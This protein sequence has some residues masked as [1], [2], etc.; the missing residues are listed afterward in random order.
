M[1][2]R[3]TP[4]ELGA[5]RARVAQN[6]YDANFMWIA[7]GDPDVLSAIFHT[8]HPGP[9]FNRGRYS[10]P[11]VDGWLEQAGATLDK[12]TRIRLYSQI[13]QRVL[14]D[15]AV[16]PLI[17]T[18]TYNAKRVEVKGDIIDALGDYV[19]LNDVYLAT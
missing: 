17:D 11:E 3:V 6:Q 7:Y 9:G 18:V 5:F 12:S 10:E 4:L 2:V 16:I 19:Y 15:G 1:D 13:Q 8:Q 14:N